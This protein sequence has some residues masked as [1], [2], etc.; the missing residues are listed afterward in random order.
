MKEIK[1]IQG[2]IKELNKNEFRPIMF[3]VHRKQK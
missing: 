3:A 1:T 2:D